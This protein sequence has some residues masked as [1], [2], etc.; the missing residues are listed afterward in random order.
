DRHLVGAAG[1]R[2]LLDRRERPRL[3]GA[4]LAVGRLG[5]QGGVEP[6]PE[7]LVVVGHGQ[8][9]QGGLDDEVSLD[10]HVLAHS[11]SSPRMRRSAAR[12]RWRREA[13]VPGATPR[14]LDASRWSKP[15]PSTSTTVTRWSTGSSARAAR[16]VSAA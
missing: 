12:A 1:G 13:T 5:G 3:G 4:G 7:A 9:P 2:D 15:S 16:T 6:L 10:G 8:E 11:T 14:I